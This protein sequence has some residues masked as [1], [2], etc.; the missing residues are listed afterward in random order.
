MDGNVGE[1]RKFLER[2][3]LIAVI[4]PNGAITGGHRRCERIRTILEHPCGIKVRAKQLA[5][6]VVYRRLTLGSLNVISLDNGH[7]QISEPRMIDAGVK[8]GMRT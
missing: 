1:A 2:A 5:R 4:H 6:T 8:Q 3:R 7:K